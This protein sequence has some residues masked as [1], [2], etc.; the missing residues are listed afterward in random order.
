MICTAYAGVLPSCLRGSF[1]Q[2]SLD[3]QAELEYFPDDDIPEQL[4][5]HTL[6]EALELHLCQTRAVVFFTVDG[7]IICDV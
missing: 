6:D 4:L 3:G 2:Q 1:V 5:E 7:R